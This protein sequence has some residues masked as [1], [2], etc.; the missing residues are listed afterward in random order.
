MEH[1]YESQFQLS[2][3]FLPFWKNSCETKDA[4]HGLYLSFFSS[5]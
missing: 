3:N 4:I 1:V 5:A 2:Q